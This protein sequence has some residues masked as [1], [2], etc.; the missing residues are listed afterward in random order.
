MSLRS[1][2]LIPALALLTPAASLAREPD[3]LAEIQR[4]AR[5]VADVMRSAMRSELKDVRVDLTIVGGRIVYER[6]SL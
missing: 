1:L 6:R 2:V 5:I 3:N 4:E